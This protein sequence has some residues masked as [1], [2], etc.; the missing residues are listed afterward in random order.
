MPTN[1]I[2][3]LQNSLLFVKTTIFLMVLRFSIDRDSGWWCSRDPNRRAC[4]LGLKTQP[5]K[6]C[7][8]T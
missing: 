8:N 1:A 5:S 6:L 4:R 2:L 7:R 3:P